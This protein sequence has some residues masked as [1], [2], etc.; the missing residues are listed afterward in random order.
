MTASPAEYETWLSS[1]IA[2]TINL[3]MI[4]IPWLQGNEKIRF[5]IASTGETKDWVV[6]SISSNLSTGTMTIGLT[7]F[8]PLYNFDVVE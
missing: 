1:K 6:Q 4:Y 2:Y 3:E 7:E 8:A 5:T